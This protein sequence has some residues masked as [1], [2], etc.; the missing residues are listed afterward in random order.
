VYLLDTNICIDFV[1]GRSANAQ[2]RVRENFAKGLHASMITVG[3]LLVGSQTSDDPDG[4]RIK[5]ERFL[6]IITVHD[7]DRDAADMYAD[8]A[9]T[10]NVKRASF[11]RLIAAHALALGFTLVTNNQKHFADVPG[12]K[13]ENWTV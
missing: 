11:D 3:E 4:D 12:L 7:F 13:V 2:R 10:I 1:D 8:I 6:S 5:V 9:R